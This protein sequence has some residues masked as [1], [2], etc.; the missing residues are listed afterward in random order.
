MTDLRARL[1][2]LGYTPG[3]AAPTPAPALPRFPS[4]DDLVEGVRVSTPHGE[5]FVA[6]RHHPAGHPHGSWRLEQALEIDT[7]AL[8]WLG[9]AA[10]LAG[11]DL[12]RTV[13]L[14]T[15]TTGLAGGTGTYAFLVGLGH[16][17]GSH[18]LVQQFFMDDY[19][20]EDALLHALADSLTP[21]SAVATFNGRA[22]DLP[23]LETRFLMAR[24]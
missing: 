5:C 18:Y 15:E 3:V 24:R 17:E 13:V 22:F 11:L 19:D 23:L 7:A 16:F 1:A 8:P 20:A 10:D 14:D 12:S 2:R 4:I 6:E 21:F 9:R